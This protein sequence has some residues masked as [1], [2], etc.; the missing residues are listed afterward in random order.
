VFFRFTKI[1]ARNAAVV[2]SGVVKKERL[3][4][5]RVL[6]TADHRVHDYIEQLRAD[7][8]F[9]AKDLMK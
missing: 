6:T 3:L 9:R 1:E 2:E 8:A 5:S 7:S 4:P